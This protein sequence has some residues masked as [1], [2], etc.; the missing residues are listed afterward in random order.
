MVDS[1]PIMGEVDWEQCIEILGKGSFS[2][3]GAK[4]FTKPIRRLYLSCRKFPLTMKGSYAIQLLN[5]Q[6]YGVQIGQV[7]SYDDD[8]NEFRW[9][10]DLNF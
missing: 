1:V 9:V 8:G 6:R 7:H 4:P 2:R 5:N 10:I 3:A